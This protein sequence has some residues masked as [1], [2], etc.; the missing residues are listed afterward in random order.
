MMKILA[1]IFVFYIFDALSSLSWKLHPT[2]WSH[3]Q[4]SPACE[5]PK[6]FLNET[7]NIFLQ[8]LYRKGNVADNQVENQYRLWAAILLFST[9]SL[10][11]FLMYKRRRD[12]QEKKRLAILKYQ[13]H[14]S[15]LKVMGSQ[16]NPH[17]IFNSL[18]SISYFIAV[19][20]SEKADQF[21]LRFSKLM[22]K[23]L[24][25]SG[26]TEIILADEMETLNLYLELESERLNHAF[27]CEVKIDPEIDQTNTL[28]PPMILQPFIENS[29]WNGYAGNDKKG[30][31][32][33]HI[34]NDKKM[35]CCIIDDKG[36]DINNSFIPTYIKNNFTKATKGVQFTKTRI[37]T[38]NKMN[39]RKGKVNFIDL[40]NGLRIELEL[41][42]ELNF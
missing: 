7:P 33:I 17:F 38:I 30:K 3:F 21:L 36:R 10:I 35:L 5:V 19:N 20:D 41:P 6:S 31:I 23:V 11:G 34:K 39:N 2:L 29:I 22:R 27:E 32:V 42:L 15:E 40:N 4:S 16:L 9:I 8:L 13:L 24:E 37:E 14:Q 1:F 26:Q 18:N 12:V 25:N 28:V